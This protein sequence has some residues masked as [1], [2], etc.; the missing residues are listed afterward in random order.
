[1]SKID[2][3]SVIE[4]AFNVAMA[5]GTT[6]S[7]DKLKVM[8]IS[9]IEIIKA[10]EKLEAQNKELEDK[11]YQIGLVVNVSISSP[12]RK[13]TAIKQILNN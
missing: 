2:E 10:F 7:H 6:E 12:S 13:M 8:E 1:M 3:S 11:L 9:F 4:M 5:N